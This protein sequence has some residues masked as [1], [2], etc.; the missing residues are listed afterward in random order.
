M[1]FIVWRVRSCCGGAMLDDKK[2]GRL[3]GESERTTR[4]SP[5]RATGAP[6]AVTEKTNQY[7]TIREA[8][9]ILIPTS[10]GRRP[11]VP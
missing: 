11:F 8:P 10:H 3:L 4:K 9:T 6:Q 7:S 2:R 1:P 5:T